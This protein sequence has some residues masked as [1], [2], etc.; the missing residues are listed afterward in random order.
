MKAV[1]SII[2]AET[3]FANVFTWF[4][5]WCL[6]TLLLLL[7]LLLLLRLF[8]ATAAAAPQP[9]PSSFPPPLPATAVVQLDGGFG[10]DTLA[11]GDGDDHDAA[12]TLTIIC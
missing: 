12:T 6:H 11:G 8:N 10:E 1:R 9:H 2:H 3:V 7:P 4:K 5:S